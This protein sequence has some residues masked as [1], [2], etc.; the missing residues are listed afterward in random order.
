MQEFS[1]AY[2]GSNGEV[3]PQKSADAVDKAFRELQKTESWRRA[4]SANWRRVRNSTAV[5]NW[6]CRCAPRPTSFVT[7]TL[8]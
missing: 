8:A 6:I 2:N 1:E 3:W 5:E 7:L 4:V